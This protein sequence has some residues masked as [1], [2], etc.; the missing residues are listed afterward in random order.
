VKLI[1]DGRPW[2]LG[3][4]SGIHSTINS[5][6]IQGQTGLSYLTSA[7]NKRL[8]EDKVM[9]L[10]S[11]STGMYQILYRVSIGGRRTTH[12][13]LSNLSWLWAQTQA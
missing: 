13:E 2:Q 9:S 12:R 11:V 6:P 7:G 4:L 5:Q 1:G 10:L 3:L 8:F